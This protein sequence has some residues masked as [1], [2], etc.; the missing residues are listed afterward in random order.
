M[1]NVCRCLF[2]QYSKG[3][4]T[5]VQ[6]ALLDIT[7][8]KTYDPEHN[9]MEWLP[10]RDCMI[11]RISEIVE[12]QFTRPLTD[13]IHNPLTNVRETLQE[14]IARISRQLEKAFTVSPPFTIL[15]IT[16]LLVE[17]TKQYSKDLPEKYL[18]A[19]ETLIFVES[20]VHE[21]PKV[22]IESHFS[23][24][25]NPQTIEMEPILWI[26]K[27]HLEEIENDLRSGGEPWDSHEKQESS[28]PEESSDHSLE[29]GSSFDTISKQS[30]DD[31]VG[32]EKENDSQLLA[33]TENKVYTTE[34]TNRPEAGSK[35]DT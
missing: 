24:D 6:K 27:E 21:F 19:L 29:N 18:K 25:G 23:K 10:L 16:E 28:V 4:L 9:P 22:E 11:K 12:T 17:P 30:S 13:I 1:S 14:S 3:T 5:A 26:T 31:S 33:S 34:E 32:N 7:K 2:F 20:G 15:R 35:S 8:R